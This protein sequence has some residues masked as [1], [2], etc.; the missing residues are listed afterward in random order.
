VL[1][2]GDDQ[3]DPI[4][5]AA[6]AILDGHIV[7]SREMAESGHYPAIDVEASISRT[8]NEI[9]DT[10]QRQNTQRFKQLYATYRHN[11]DLINVGAYTRGTDSRI[12]EAIMMQPLLNEFLCQDMHEATSWQQSVEDLEALLH[13]PSV[14][15]PSSV[16]QALPI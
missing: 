7:L 4:A 12:D 9:V 15:T 11:Q 3:Q 14:E 16:P 1:T 8:M 13:P 2:E 5:D 10:Q 6:R